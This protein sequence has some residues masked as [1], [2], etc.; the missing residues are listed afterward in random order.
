MLE[1]AMAAGAGVG[2]GQH[3]GQDSV[4]QPQRRVAK[5]GQ[6]KAL[7]QF[8]EDLGAGHD[9][10]RPARPDAGHGFAL[11]QRHLRE[12]CSQ[13]ANQL[14]WE[15]TRSCRRRRFSNWYRRAASVFRR[16]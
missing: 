3:L 13:L 16:F 11:R 4:A 7:Q 10:L 8:R 15:R 1:F 6:P 5:T 2:L 12:F 14:A 9:D